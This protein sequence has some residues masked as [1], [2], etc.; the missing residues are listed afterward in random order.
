MDI[1]L[2]VRGT[3]ALGV[4]LFLGIF[5]LYFGYFLFTRTTKKIDEEEEIAGGNIAVGITAAAFIFS[6]GY[7]MESVIDPF[8]QTLFNTAAYASE[9]YGRVFTGLGIMTLQ[10]FGTLLISL[11]VLLGGQ[12][13]FQSLTRHLD[14]WQEIQNNNI[15]VALLNGAMLITLALFLKG[16]LEIFLDFLVL[17]PGV[18][19]TTALPFG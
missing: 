6:L 2:V 4:S 9:G 15:A 7:M 13:I 17:S 16:G 14:E 8:M 19:S 3:A 11:A 1:L 18:Q 12:K 5:I 10:I